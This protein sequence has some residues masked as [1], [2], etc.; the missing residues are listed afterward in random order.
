MSRVVDY[1]RWQQCLP[2]SRIFLVAV[3]LSFLAPAVSVFGQG[4]SSLIPNDTYYTA[5]RS[6]R[7]GDYGDAL[8]GFREAARGGVLGVDGRWIDA[9]CYHTMAGE[10]FYQMGRLGEALDQYEAALHLY[11]KFK[12]WMLRVQFPDSIAE[13]SGS[14]VRGRITFGPSARASKLGRFPD[15]LSILMGRLDNDQIVLQGGGVV[16]PPEFRP[17]KV[18]EILRCTALAIR[19]R[20]EIMGP[21]CKHDPFT[22]EIVDAASRLA[23]PPNHWSQAWAEALLGFAYAAADRPTEAAASLQRSLL[24]ERQFD[25]P[26]TGDA[27]YELGKIAFQQGKYETAKQF[28]HESTLSAAQFDHFDVMEE[29]FRQGAITHMVTGQ[30]GIY[31]PLVEAAAWADRRSRPLQTS[32]LLLAAECS[33]AHSATNDAAAFLAEVEQAMG[34]GQMLDSA[35]G[36]RY[37][38]QAA[39]VNYQQGNIAKGNAALAS[40]MEFQREGSKRLFQI[41]LADRLYLNDEISP[42]IA[43]DLFAALLGEPTE[44]DWTVDPMETLS[45][46]VTP[47]LPSLEHWLEV[48]LIDRKDQEAGLE[49]ADAIRRH[50][51]H[52]GLPLGGRLLALRWVL[53]AP[54]SALN[55][56]ARLQR[57]SL[58]VK[59]PAYA[60][61]S[62]QARKILDELSKISLRPDDKD[63]VTEQARLL[64]ELG[65]ITT[66][67]EVMLTDMALRRVPSEFMFPPLRKTKEIQAAM[68]E[69][70]LTIAYLNTS[71][72][73]LRFVVSKKEINIE[74]IPD[75]AQV[76]RLTAALL[77]DMGHFDKNMA[78]GEAQLY[79]SDWKTSAKSIFAL[80]TD[81]IKPNTWQEYDELVVVPDGI[82]WY[83]PFEALQLQLN[84]ELVSLMSQIRIRYAPTLATSVPYGIGHRRNGNFAVVAGKL[85]PRDT[86]E[87][88][89]AAFEDLRAA[90]P[91][92]ARIEFPL[93]APSSLF[94]SMCNRLVVLDE[95]DDMVAD[96]FAWSPMQVDRGKPGSELASWLALPWPGPEQIILPGFH[97]AASDG[98]R[99]GGTG[100]EVFLTVCG[101]MASGSRTVL[102][103]RWRTGG[104]TSV[105]LTREFARGL[106]NRSAS[107]A[108]QRSVQLALVTE[109]DPEREPRI[110]PAGLKPGLTAEHPF[111]WSGYLLVD[112]GVDPKRD[113]P[114]D[115]VAPVKPVPKP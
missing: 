83:V 60:E 29:A 103:S 110:K 13:D 37:Q 40:A 100:D 112:S 93:P 30:K 48:M 22:G 45:V 43:G 49:I 99:H 21:A 89:T 76:E 52:V 72:A 42:R 70:Q 7:M 85:F 115:A 67:Q 108:W 25:H 18:D 11:I 39:H 86:A 81:K 44:H 12:D 105:D 57:Q 15:K 58:L 26:L 1:S 65:R 109:I 33:A 74:R 51:F 102:L 77:R 78:I 82:L 47:H 98:L 28:F 56:R 4:G 20:G 17:V 46:L 111:F 50:R 104:Q 54:A 2:V 35:I 68:P 79:S 73:V 107:R 101:L 53:E 66:L 91:G 55:E 69:G 24:V 34:R 94:A 6:F 64:D 3:L 71:T 10:C 96:H 31:P 59:F 8:L 36:A 90:V 5:K 63:L 16:S 14:S 113:E 84:G 80:V 106:S 61:L 92:A 38:F 41:S 114:A 88:T 19:R 87:V 27:L 62:R 23:A 95:I 97:T 9:I 75:A 32:L